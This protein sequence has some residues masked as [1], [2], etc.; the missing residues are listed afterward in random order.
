MRRLRALIC[1]FISPAETLDGYEQPELVDVVFRK[2]RA[3]EP[4][5]TWP[6]VIGASSVLDFGGGCGL[7]YKQANS[8]TVRWAVVETPAMVERARELS[9]D[10]LQF[11][12]DIRDAADW[13]GP[14][15]LMHS[16]GALQYTH[17]PEQT[18]R[19]LCAL[20]AEKMLWHRLFF[21]DV[22]KQE[23]QSSFLGDNGP[24]SLDV[25]EKIVRYPRTA[26][27]ESDFLSAHSG[28]EL[29]ERGAGWAR[30]HKRSSSRLMDGYITS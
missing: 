28:Y 5:A 3:Y 23:I 10:R 30:F 8:A 2:T 20:G 12:T 25:R 17:E 15:N 29:M 14:I 18:L 27:I 26:I 7:H 1:R 21:A 11:F 16:D 9:T 6:E 24:G 19:D 13:L 22:R 4:R